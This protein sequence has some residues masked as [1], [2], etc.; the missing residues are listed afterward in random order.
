MAMF[1]G[2]FSLNDVNHVVSV[3]CTCYCSLIITM[4]LAAIV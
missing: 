4:L 2:K 1:S 3:T